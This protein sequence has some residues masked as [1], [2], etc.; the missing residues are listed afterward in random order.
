[1]RAKLSIAL[2]IVLMLP[3]PARAQELS[4]PFLCNVGM[5]EAPMG[6]Y[7]VCHNGLYAGYIGRARTEWGGMFICR[8][9]DSA[10][11]HENILVRL[12]KPAGV[13][14]KRGQIVEC[15]ILYNN[16]TCDL[17]KYPPRAAMPQGKPGDILG[18]LDLR[19]TR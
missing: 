4:A 5:D 19:D 16:A 7:F 6:I 12:T 14:L 2:T 18:P 15:R 9:M 1:M 17:T 10:R 13:T 11:C 8:K 3:L